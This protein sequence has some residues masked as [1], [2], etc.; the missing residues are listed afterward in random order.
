M[1][2]RRSKRKVRCSLPDYQVQEVLS[3]QDIKQNVGW[4]ITAFDLPK[5]WESTQGEGVVIAVLDTGCDLDH[6]DLKNNLLP[7]INFI[8]RNKEPN[9]D[10]QHGCVSPETYIHT[11]LYGISKIVDLYDKCDAEEFVVQTGYIKDV[12]NMGIKTYSLNT[13]TGETEVGEIEYL[14]KT[15]IDSKIVEVN[16][17]GNISLQL[18]PWHPV[19]TKKRIRK[20]V[21]KIS[22][23][24]A[25]ELNLK[26]GLIFPTNTSY[27]NLNTEYV[28]V[29][30]RPRKKCSRCGHV[31]R[32]FNNLNSP[33]KKCFS[34]NCVVVENNYFINEELAY[35]IGLVLTDGH[36][37]KQKNCRLEITSVTQE[38]LIRSKEILDKHGFKSRIDN[39][40]NRLLCDSKELISILENSG[41]KCFEKSY[42]QELPEFVGKSPKSVISAFI[43]G[44]ID[45]DGCI[46]KNNTSNRITT[47]SRNFA[48]QMAYL[49]N[50]MSIS[51]GVFKYKNYK[52]SKNRT[53]NDDNSLLIPIYNCTFS[54]LNKEITNY[55]HHPEKNK[56]ASKLVNSKKRS[57]RPI[58]SIETK[59]ANEYFYD[60]TVKNYKTYIANG[61][62]V[63][64]THV[65][66][67]ICAENNE[68]GMVGVAPKAK[69]IPVKVLDAKGNG[70]MNSVASG[71]S[72]AAD[73]GADIISMS[74]GCPSPLNSTL[75]AIKYAASK[76]VVT[77]CAAGNAGV[78][79]E[80]FYPAN[81]K[82]TI[83][84][85]S[86][87]ENFDRSSFSNTGKNL[88]FLAPGGQIFSTVPDNWYAILSGTSMACPFAV[89]VAALCLSYQRKYF[90]EHPLKSAQAYRDLLKSHTVP[91]SNPE[92]ANKQ[93]FQ[94]FG[95][96]DP[97]K[98]KEWISQH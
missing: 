94:G 36:L 29:L 45:G 49:L 20:D 89:G 81:Y 17:T 56:R 3:M 62:F 34:K 58:K 22:K 98:L 31:C 93:F 88:D 70:D 69:V 16:L 52:F 48:F 46:G 96:I 54:S 79:K 19:Y 1:S 9:D 91:V 18:T 61:H 86:I 80:I 50:S 11:N 7:G 82:E 84:V 78:T 38:L 44:V 53:D 13:E 37:N 33:C 92:Y 47:V 24:R 12:R 21:Y 15:F 26:D 77:F 5:A 55:L 41:I 75:K 6:P 83:S 51:A 8:N 60:F 57:I 39:S 85:G 97:R 42:N 74:L 66:G 2:Q 90:P 72:W 73:N 40:R 59:N 87:D 23:I 32:S 35:L 95:I 10:N 4:G 28:S 43:A 65:T 63:S 25:D 67:I 68:I 14:H 30:G 27:K 76:G 64:N 71:I